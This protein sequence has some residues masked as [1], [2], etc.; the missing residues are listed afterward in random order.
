MLRQNN[1]NKIRRHLRIYKK[2]PGASYRRERKRPTL[3]YPG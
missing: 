1:K 2:S 3:S